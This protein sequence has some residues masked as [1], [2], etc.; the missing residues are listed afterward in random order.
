MRKCINRMCYSVLV[1]VL[2]FAMPVQAKSEKQQVNISAPSKVSAKR[3]TYNSIFIKWSKVAKASGYALYR[4][5]SKNGTYTRIATIKS[6]KSLEYI[7]KRCICGKTYYYKI[8][9]YR[10]SGKKNDYGKET[11]WV[12]TKT[13][14][15]KVKYASGIQ[16]GATTVTL[17][18]GKTSGANGYEIYCSE[19]KNKEYKLVKTITNQ[20][21]LKWKK[22]KLKDN[23]TYYFKIRAY[24]KINGKKIYGP[25]SSIYTKQSVA[26][27]LKKLEKYMSVPYVYGGTTSKGWDCSGFTQWTMKNMYGISIARASNEQARGGKK[28]NKNNMSKWK[29]G[30]LLFFSSGGKINHVGIYLGDGKMIHALNSKYDMLI[31]DVKVYEKW[32]KKNKLARVKR[33]LM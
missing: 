1:I 2:L 32:D 30:D 12:A 6:E 13:T 17:R 14:P 29:P 24:V 20:K 25:Y 8:R 33:Y 22:T 19:K 18:W 28:I 21:I 10:T 5:T 27:K 9:A 31:Q 15:C 16:E 3:Q 11:N 23:K 4:S 7:D 26:T